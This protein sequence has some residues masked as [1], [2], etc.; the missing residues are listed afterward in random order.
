M[1]DQHL[2]ETLSKLEEH[3][4]KERMSALRQHAAHNKTSITKLLGE[5]V[6]AYVATLTA[7]ASR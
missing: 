2:A 4:G 3:I 7:T 1:S 5:A 6:M